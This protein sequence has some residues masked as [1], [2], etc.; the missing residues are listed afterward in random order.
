MHFGEMKQVLTERGRDD[1][2][3][4]DEFNINRS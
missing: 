4:M 3:L 2:M 1:Q